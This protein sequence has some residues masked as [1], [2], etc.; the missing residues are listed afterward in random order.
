[1][2][3]ESVI[4]LKY[5]LIINYR[6]MSCRTFSNSN[7]WH[8][9][10]VAGLGAN[11]DARRAVFMY[12]FVFIY[13][14]SFIYYFVFLGIYWGSYEYLKSTMITRAHR[15]ETTFSISFIS[16]AVAGSVCCC[17]IWFI[18]FAYFLNFRLPA[19]SHCHSM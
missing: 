9:C 7:E 14:F 2:Q 10:I 15:Q 13:L 19:L 6:I 1:M 5:K 12:V 3:V 18:Y 4:L 16:G 8:T 17:I 11:N